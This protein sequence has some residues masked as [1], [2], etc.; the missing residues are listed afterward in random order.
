M[1]VSSVGAALVLP[2]L[3]AVLATRPRVVCLPAALCPAQAGALGH[4]VALG[5]LPPRRVSGSR[6][7]LRLWPLVRPLGPVVLPLRHS[8]LPSLLRGEDLSCPQA[9]LCSRSAGELVNSLLCLP[10]F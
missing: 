10:S 7:L 4:R 3:S 5:P 2:G 9:S 6:Q 8:C 1:L